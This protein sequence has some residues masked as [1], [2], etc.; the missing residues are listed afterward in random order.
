MRRQI[1]AFICILLLTTAAWSVQEY[2]Q[3]KK[4]T[5]Y[6]LTNPLGMTDPFEL[7]VFLDGIMRVHMQ[8]RHIAGAT[9]VAVKDDEIFFA[10][11]YGYADIENKIPVSPERTL[12]R[13][14]SVSKLFVWTAVM[15]LWEIGKLDL[16]TDI[17]VY[18]KDFQIPETFPEP[19]TMRHLLTHT[20]GF[21]ESIRGILAKTAEDLVPLGEF[22]ADNMPAR[23]YPPG[24]VAAYSNYGTAL[25]GYIVEIL[26][27]MPF[28]AYVEERIFQPLG[29]RFSSFRQPLPEEIAKYMSIGYKYRGGAFVP[30]DFE[31]IYGLAPAGSLSASA[32]DMAK[33][34]IT[35]LQN[36]FYRGNRILYEGT[37]QLM[38]SR[39]FSHDARI[40]GNAYGF[41]EDRYNNLEMLEHGG[42]TILFHSS[43]ILIPKL[44]I[45][46]FVSYNSEGGGGKPRGQLLRALLDRY[47]PLMTETK[48]EP[49]QGLS[50]RIRDF[51][52]LYGS[53]R[54]N[55]SSFA[56]I[57]QLLAMIR[58]NGTKEGGLLI[59]GGGGLKRYVEVEPMVFREKDGQNVAVFKQNDRGRITHLFLSQSPHTANIRLEWYQAPRIHIFILLLIT[60]M[61][62]TTLIWPLGALKRKIFGQ[63]Q[64]GNPAPPSA[65]WLAGGMSI[66]CLIFIIGGFVLFS[67]PDPFNYGPPLSFKILLTLPFIAAALAVGVVIY[68]FWG[69]IKG[70][71]NVSSRI[72]YLMVLLTF[73]LFLWFLNY[74]NLLGFKF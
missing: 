56:K 35:H 47:Y 27:G 36:G 57:V 44:N 16:E 9:F 73:A 32:M 67:N 74:W 15:Q 53:T 50:R 13:P 61:F 49:L 69:W 59:S 71:W 8:D 10:K 24:I 48:T 66:L 65:R 6:A 7:E 31:L 1:C 46:F 52:G 64:E 37:A 12:F 43:M 63:L 34:M 11:G 22:L 19:I 39:L 42:D 4:L 18:L 30:Q 54:V 58:V 21:E 33:F 2:E 68:V 23:V 41:W 51:T 60:F 72:H 55:H 25:A 62:L 45:G 14:G 3:T 5:E 70:Y 20:P 38:H 17:N 26:S 40:N 29:M 28:E